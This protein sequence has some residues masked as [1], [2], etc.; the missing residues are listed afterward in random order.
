MKNSKVGYYKVGDTIYKG[1][2]YYIG[3]VDN[4]PI[5][6]T[7]IT[8]VQHNNDKDNTKNYEFY[9]YL[10]VFPNGNTFSLFKNT[11]KNEE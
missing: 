3:T 5:H 6:I 8:T 4:V 11:T 7:K 10:V 2:L 9:E 1:Y